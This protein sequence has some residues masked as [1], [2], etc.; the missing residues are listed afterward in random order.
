MM[1]WLSI[2]GCDRKVSSDRERDRAPPRGGKNTSDSRQRRVSSVVTSYQRTMARPNYSGEKRR[3]ELEKQR[4]KEEKKKR[5]LENASALRHRRWCGRRRRDRLR[6]ASYG[7]I[8]ELSSGLAEQDFI[9]LIHARHFRL[10]TSGGCL[11]LEHEVH[12]LDLPGFG[13][14]DGPSEVQS[15]P[16]LADSILAWMSAVG[17]QQC[18][19]VANSLGCEIVAHLAIKAPDRSP[20]CFDWARS[21]RKP[22]PVRS[23]HEAASSCAPR[24]HPTLDELELRFFPRRPSQSDWH[25]A[26]DFATTS[27]QL[28]NISSCVLVNTAGE[29]PPRRSGTGDAEGSYSPPQHYIST[30]LS[31]RIQAAGEGVV[32]RVN[33]GSRDVRCASGAGSRSALVSSG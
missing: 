11:A 27:R 29:P 9:D 2:P 1:A 18:H 16:Q 26:R 30:A 17:I 5:K 7:R 12:A 24:A 4:K 31:G 22:L 13:R 25:H 15:V 20:P 14:S 21:I 28:R 19:L 33:P 10:F 23:D 6:R 8:A 32:T 3:K